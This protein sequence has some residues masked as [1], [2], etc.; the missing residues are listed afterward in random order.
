MIEEMLNRDWAEGF[1]DSERNASIEESDANNV[2]GAIQQRFDAANG[3]ASGLTPTGRVGRQIATIGILGTCVA[4]ACAT[5]PALAIATGTIAGLGV[6]AGSVACCLGVVKAIRARKMSDYD[7]VQ[8]AVYGLKMSG[9]SAEKAQ[10]VGRAYLAAQDLVRKNSTVTRYGSIYSD[11]LAGWWKSRLYLRGTNKKGP[12]YQIRALR[13]NR[14]ALLNFTQGWLK[15]NVDIIKDGTASVAA[16]SAIFRK[17]SV[18]NVFGLDEKE[19]LETGTKLPLGPNSVT[20]TPQNPSD[21]EDATA[22]SSEKPLKKEPNQEDYVNPEP[23]V[24]RSMEEYLVYLDQKLNGRLDKASGLPSMTDEQLLVFRDK[25]SNDTLNEKNKIEKIIMKTSN[26]GKE[27]A[28]KKSMLEKIADIENVRNE[29]SSLPELARFDYFAS[30]EQSRKT[31]SK[32]ADRPYFELC[33]H[34]IILL[35]DMDNYFDLV[36]D[37]V[38]DGFGAMIDRDIARWNENETEASAEN[39]SQNDSGSEAEDLRSREERIRDLDAETKRRI[40]GIELLLSKKMPEEEFE[41][42]MRAIEEKCG[43]NDLEAVRSMVL[44]DYE[45]RLAE[46]NKSESASEETIKTVEHIDFLMKEKVSSNP[47][48]S[49]AAFEDAMEEIRNEFGSDDLEEIRSSILNNHQKQQ[50]EINESGSEKPVDGKNRRSE[51]S[52]FSEEIWNQGTGLGSQA[53]TPRPF[54]Q[55]PQV[56]IVD[57]LTVNVPRSKRSQNER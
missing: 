12:S 37:T 24:F 55:V 42:G 19:V 8:F 13:E 26:S 46:I 23:L 56:P 43:T 45:A 53:M 39:S 14:K 41:R 9:L 51:N 34:D 15:G 3:D 30:M 29:M 7:F 6:V 38:I 36:R 48:L 1:K 5:V 47:T 16:I 21:G 50:L 33:Y 18:A 10:E 11:T 4:V 22:E 52:S 20:P 28:R 49:K 2:F 44:S 32:M 40:D 35:G 57:D 54:E 31:M 27:G 17:N 25:V